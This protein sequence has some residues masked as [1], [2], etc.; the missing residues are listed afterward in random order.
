MKPSLKGSL[1]KIV[2]FHRQQFQQFK[3]EYGKKVIGKSKLN[4]LID[5]SENI[6]VLFTY[7]HHSLATITHTFSEEPTIFADVVEELSQRS[8]KFLETEKNTSI[9]PKTFSS[10]KPIT[11]DC[12]LKLMF[13]QPQSLFF[14]QRHEL[15][16]TEY[17]WLISEDILNIL[18][19]NIAWIIKSQSPHTTKITSSDIIQIY[20]RI[21]KSSN[22]IAIDDPMIHLI[23]LVSCTLSD[24]FLA[25]ATLCLAYPESQLQ[26]EDIKDKTSSIYVDLLS[27]LT[28]GLYHVWWDRVIMMP[29]ANPKSVDLTTLQ[30]YA[31]IWSQENSTKN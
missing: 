29:L 28:I 3:V 15:K 6:P 10:Q 8:S 25:A 19:I 2:S 7:R 11:Y 14:Q 5:G 22:S 20:Q 12:Y 16:K 17:W 4:Q 27:K 1:Q 24:P 26:T 13:H 30:E 9:I 18:S 31:R 21:E 23:R